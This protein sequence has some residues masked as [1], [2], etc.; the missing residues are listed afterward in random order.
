MTKNILF[1]I[2][3]CL[4]TIT[5]FAQNDDLKTLVNNHDSCIHFFTFYNDTA[6]TKED[7]Y[8]LFTYKFGYNSCNHGIGGGYFK[9][10]P[11]TITHISTSDNE[12]SSKEYSGYILDDVYYYMDRVKVGDQ[13]ILA[14]SDKNRHNIRP[15]T[16]T[17]KSRQIRR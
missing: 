1:V 6:M 16:I 3:I 8:T 9:D 15:Q 2:L 10:L 14:L 4:A 5:C 13:L 17:I 7:I 12:T 11:Y